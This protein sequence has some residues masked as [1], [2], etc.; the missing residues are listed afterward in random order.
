[1]IVFQR[2]VKH[3]APP[4]PAPDA[5]PAPGPDGRRSRPPGARSGGCGGRFPATATHR[6]PRSAR[7]RRTVP[8]LAA[9][10]GFQTRD[11][12]GTLCHSGSRDLLGLKHLLSQTF[13]PEFA[14][15]R[16]PLCE[17]W[18]LATPVK[19]GLANGL[20]HQYTVGIQQ[21]RRPRHRHWSWRVE[22]GSV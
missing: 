8:P 17:K 2:P 1:M 3:A 16:Q 12:L 9:I 19:K 7:R 14:A 13:M 15:F 4:S 22:V 6:R 5:E 20:R 11:R 21:A 18:R 10:N